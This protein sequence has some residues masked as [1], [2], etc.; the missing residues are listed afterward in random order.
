M[1]L[2]YE[3]FL[4]SWLLSTNLRSTAHN[5]F[6]TYLKY[7]G[8]MPQKTTLKIGITLP[9]PSV[10]GLPHFTTFIDFKTK[11]LWNRPLYK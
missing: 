9:G 4:K 1:S 5:M 11:Y 2:I 8:K 3:I 6:I 7:L 10:M